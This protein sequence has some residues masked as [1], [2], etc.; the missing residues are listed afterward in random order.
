MEKKYNPI[1]KESGKVEEPAIEYQ[2]Q[3]KVKT[4][5]P[6][7]EE[8]ISKCITGDELIASAYKFIDEL[9]DKD[10]NHLH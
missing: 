4:L 2:R 6:L 5:P 9:F 8:E 10:E 3:I 7:T 1:P